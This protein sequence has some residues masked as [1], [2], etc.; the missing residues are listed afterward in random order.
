MTGAT[1]TMPRKKR[2]DTAT[3]IDAEI[4]RKAKTIAA[5][6]EISVAEYLSNFLKPIIDREFEKFRHDLGDHPKK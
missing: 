1:A 2:N 3:K 5:Y 4:I 6:K